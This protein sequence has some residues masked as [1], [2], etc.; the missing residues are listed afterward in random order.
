ML[1]KERR[2]KTLIV[3]LLI[4]SFIAGTAFGM[5]YTLKH[6]EA[7]KAQMEQLVAKERRAVVDQVEILSLQLRSF[8]DAEKRFEDAIC[9]SLK[10]EIPQPPVEQK[11]VRP[12]PTPTPHP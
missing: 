3:A 1:E 11:K 4:L 6:T 7:L 2:V 10:I 9:T 5:M 12:T 8:W